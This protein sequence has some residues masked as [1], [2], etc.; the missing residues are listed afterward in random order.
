M[1]LLSDGWKTARYYRTSTGKTEIINE[2]EVRVDGKFRYKNSKKEIFT[3]KSSI[4]PSV[5]LSGGKRKNL[6]AHI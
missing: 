4:Y 6:A 1:L 3:T 5:I 2:L